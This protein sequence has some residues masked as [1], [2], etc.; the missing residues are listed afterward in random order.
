MASDC[1]YRIRKSLDKYAKEGRC[2]PRTP[3]MRSMSH[4]FQ[5]LWGYKIFSL[6]K[7]CSRNVK[8]K[9]DW[10]HDVDVTQEDGFVRMDLAVVG[11]KS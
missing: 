3:S 7:L 8:S 11:V 5:N 10:D 4:E 1:N 2:L 6:G 9:G